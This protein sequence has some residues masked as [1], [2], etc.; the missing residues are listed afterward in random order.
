MKLET[1]TLILVADGAKYLIL[2]NAGW[3]AKLEL[4]VLS[5]DGIDNP[6]TRDQA[7]DRAGVLPGNSDWSLS[8]MEQTDVHE[9][10]ET[11][12]AGQLVTKLN[13]WAEQNWFKNI[14]IVAD[15]ET[16][17]QMRRKYSAPLKDRLIREIPKDLTN[18]TIHDIQAVLNAA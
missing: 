11:E 10:R 13:R 1:K 5:H 17:G 18:L 9:L 8:A 7:K 16:L 4:R 3:P 12:F 15:P 14:V 6:P 2:E